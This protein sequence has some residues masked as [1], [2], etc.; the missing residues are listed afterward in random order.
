L[1]INTKHTRYHRQII[2]KEFGELAQQKLLQ[3]KVL[4]IGAGGLGC[5]ALQYLAG[6]GVGV[7]GIVDS[8]VVELSNLQRQVLYT[9][10]DIG[11]SKAET[12]VKRLAALNPESEF[13]HFNLRLTNTNALDVIKD[14]DIVIDGSDNFS[15]RYLVNDACVILNKPLVYG[16]VLR[17][18]GQVAVF[19]MNDTETSIKTNYRDL[20]P[21]A[22][23]FSLSCNE[24]GVLGVVP[25]IIGTMQAAEAIKIIT[26]IGKPLV[27]KLLTYN[28][29]NNNFYDLEIVNSDLKLNYPRTKES[30][31]AYDYDVSC[32]SVNS[33]ISQ[34]EFE[35]LRIESNVVIIDVRENDELPIVNE[36]DHIKL[37]LSRLKLE[38]NAIASKEQMII[39]C[40]SGQRSLQAV[41]ILKKHFSSA[42]IFSLK[43]GIVQY[44]LASE[45]KY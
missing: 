7:I 44:L 29:L 13:I 32:N 33:E 6:A 8:D 14:F 9:T 43:G 25:G 17:F 30:L 45:S 38:L 24:A 35:Q 18:E 15:T 22:P 11:N 4:V 42:K 5:P 27:N 10:N 36:F 21:E 39:F 20:F 41:N 23:E 37:P 31:M 26:G 19:N 2:L 3:A 16:A 34:K 40:N 28:V 1:N 12:A